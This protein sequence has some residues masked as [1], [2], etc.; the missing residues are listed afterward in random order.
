MIQREG[1]P[2]TQ[3][4]AMMGT[5]EYM[6]PEAFQGEELDGR[7]DIWSFGVL[8]FEMLAGERPF[9]G[10]QIAS[11]IAAILNNPPPDLLALRPYT[12]PALARLIERM[13]VKERGDRIGR[14]RLVAA[15]LDQIRD[16]L[17]KN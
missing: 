4:R 1:T 13:L 2:L 12:P 6:S 16:Q 14:M 5:M 15:E 9:T 10:D 7:T 8:L 17:S 3:G 11:I